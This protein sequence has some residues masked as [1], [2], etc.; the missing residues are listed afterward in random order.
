MADEPPA[1]VVIIGNTS[2][3]KERVMIWENVF[4]AA[5][6]LMWAVVDYD[7]VH[8]SLPEAPPGDL[9]KQLDKVCHNVLFK[10]AETQISFGQ[11][12]FLICPRL[13]HDSRAHLDRLL[14]LADENCS[15]VLIIECKGR[16]H[17]SGSIDYV[18]SDI[19]YR[20]LLL[21]HIPPL[22]SPDSLENF[23]RRYIWNLADARELF[24]QD[25]TSYTGKGKLRHFAHHH[26]LKLEESSGR[27]CS[28]CAVP[29]SGPCYLCLDC[30]AF[31]LHKSCADLPQ[32]MNLE[33]HIHPLTLAS[34]TWEMNELNDCSQFRHR[35]E[36]DRVIECA[37]CNLN[38]TEE[39]KPVYGCLQCYSFF[40]HYECTILAEPIIR[41]DCHEHTLKLSSIK[42]PRGSYTFWCYAC[43]NSGSKISYH[44]SE[45]DLHLHVQCARILTPYVGKMCPHGQPLRLTSHV[46][47][48]DTDEY[49]CEVCA[50]RRHP[51]YWIYYCKRCEYEAHPHCVLP[52]IPSYAY[53]EQVEVGGKTNIIDN[54][55]DFSV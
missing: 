46:P 24:K 3:P 1:I 10:I 17:E 14:N 21:R 53:S 52:R 43:G 20:I 6:E 30:E 28:V 5:E 35:G 48:D 4:S 9:R 50:N 33:G 8:S 39:H 41:F 18:V 31:S 22:G 34:I 29:V 54:D 40:L 16:N 55:E 23:I 47:K 36:L 2:D 45:C 11:G 13:S 49:Y 51:D 37:I 15:Q 32:C 42:K 44:C 26:H 38:I 7:D 12:I 19:P 27:I 25:N